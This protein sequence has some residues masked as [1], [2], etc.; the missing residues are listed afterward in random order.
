MIGIRDIIRV[1]MYVH[2]KN[3]WS[4]TYGKTRAEKQTNV[5]VKTSYR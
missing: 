1:R 2:I 3:Q 4:Y 5:D